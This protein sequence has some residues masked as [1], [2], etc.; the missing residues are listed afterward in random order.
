M[1]VWET[2]SGKLLASAEGNHGTSLSLAFDPS[3]HRLAAAYFNL[4]ADIME[5]PGLR[6]LVTLTN[7]QGMVYDAKFSHDGKWLLTS[8]TENAALLWDALTG[9]GPLV[10]FP[11]G[12]GVWAANFSSDSRSVVTASY[13]STV[14]VWDRASG[15][16]LTEPLPLQNA[17][18]K[19]QFSPNDRCVITASGEGTAMVWDVRTGRA[20]SEPFRHETGVQS[21]CFSP[22]GKHIMIAGRDGRVAFHDWLEIEDQPPAWLPELAEAVGG[23]RLTEN[24]VAEFLEDAAQIL[25]RLRETLTHGTASDSVARWGQWYLADRSTRSISPYS[26]ISVRNYAESLAQKGELPM[27]EEALNLGSRNPRIYRKLAKL[28]ENALPETGA[29]YERLAVALG[30][31]PEIADPAAAVTS[32][33]PASS[34]PKSASSGEIRDVDPLDTQELLKHVGKTV[35]VKGKI[36]QYASGT[37]GNHLFLNFSQNYRAGMVL[38]FRR[39]DNPAEFRPE[40]LRAFVN[41]VVIVEAKLTLYEGRPEFEIKSLAEIKKIEDDQPLSVHAATATAI[42][43][44]KD[45][46]PQVSGNG[47]PVLDPLHADELLKHEGR[48]IKITGRVTRLSTAPS[49]RVHYLNFSDNFRSSLSLVCIPSSNPAEFRPELLR[50][51]VN[52]TVMVEGRMESYQ[53]LPKW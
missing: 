17:F 9:E 48:I 53:G 7:S 34:S 22:D 31:T 6:V 35:R 1:S 10:K 8:S 12:S 25:I 27:L 4:R 20:L 11:H 3:G 19:G 47:I 46:A 2:A 29:L 36:L 39:K 18:T 5:L 28:V 45:A 44:A 37:T 52:K 15:R 51:F 26:R 43:T 16:P 30:A 50:D 13:D 38:V 42:A 23:Y 49:G 33:S 41:Q 32:Q 14:R 21:A 40:L 24:G